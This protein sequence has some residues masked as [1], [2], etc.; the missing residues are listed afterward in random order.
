MK[1]YEKI[2][3]ILEPAT[4]YVSGEELA[5][6]LGISRTSVW[7]GIQQLE[8]QG[9]TIK[10]GPNRGYRLEQGDLL[11][12]EEIAQNLN[13]PVYLTKDSTSTQ[14]DAR[15]GIER[16]DQS[17]ALYLAPSQ[18]QAQGRF[19]RSFFTAERGGIYMT[20]RLRPEASFQ[21]LKPYTLFAAAAIV[22]AIEQL[23]SIPVAIKWVN[24]IYRDGKKIAGILT[25]AISSVEAQ[26]VTDM[27]IGVGLNFHLLDLPEELSETATSLFTDTPPITR[28]QLIT[29]I[30]RIFFT[31]SEEELLAIYKEKSLVLGKQVTFS[32]QNQ[33]YCG[34]A[35]AIT[36]TGALQ[37]QLDNGNLKT[38][39]SGEVSLS[40][41]SDSPRP[42]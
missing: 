22:K 25:E 28:N 39:S 19:G 37:V 32:Q 27:M 38:L 11:L 31:T 8:K 40:S 17:P 42:E 18:T 36:D 9:L 2:Y 30:W 15:R 6:R 3:R 5:H 29:E 20:L 12:P 26:I 13:I 33:H 41:W 4:D 24:D 7:K 23:T 21:D 14:L 10:A 35:V 1:T 16:Q 34:V